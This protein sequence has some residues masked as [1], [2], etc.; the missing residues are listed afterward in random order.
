MNSSRFETLT[1]TVDLDFPEY[2]APP[3][4][5]IGLVRRWL[6]AAVERHVREPLSLA[7]ATADDRG[8][9]SNRTVTVNA[10][11][12]E[13]LVFATHST[14]QKGRELAATGWAS[15]LFY[16]R[17][18]S[19]QLIL[20][21]PVRRLPDTESDAIWR[22]RPQMLHP[23]SVA[24]WQS[25]RLADAASLRAEAC[26]LA[27]QGAH[28]PLARPDRFAGYRLE[29]STVEFWCASSD[30]LHRRLRYDRTGLA[31]RSSRL[32]P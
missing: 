2:D 29:P 22:A 18:T 28:A 13:G 32:Q 30:R 16:W 7:L 20:S 8:R 10:V 26:H 23:M 9:A 24:S 21:G 6:A 14:S 17:E 3:P 27:T 11:T 19:Q 1:G 25:Q 12:D 5:P 4:E 31:W 15:G